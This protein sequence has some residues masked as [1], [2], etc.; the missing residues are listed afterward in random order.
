MLPP[1]LDQV[2]E[3]GLAEEEHRV[4]VDL[5]QPVVG[6]LVHLGEVVGAG[7]AGHVGEDVDPS[8]T[9]GAVR[10]RGEALAASREVTG[11]GVALRTGLDDP[12]ERALEAGG[13][14]VVGEDRGPLGR[15]AQGRGAT[16]AGGG[17][18]D[19]RDLPVEA[20]GGRG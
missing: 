17:A 1:V 5:H 10:H 13:V 2:R 9:L 15:Q 12:G 11:P 7:D 8:G 3:G 20:V 18:G 16:D 19:E 4:H 6:G 14:D